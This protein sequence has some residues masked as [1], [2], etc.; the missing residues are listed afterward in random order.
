MSEEMPS[1]PYPDPMSPMLAIV[2][3]QALGAHERGEASVRD[4]V[5]YA[6]VHGWYEG[7]IEGEDRCSGCDDRGS[8]PEAS[9]RL[10]SSPG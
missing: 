9:E 6:A 8:D 7:H 1:P 2:I 4:A 5:L 3:D 10:R